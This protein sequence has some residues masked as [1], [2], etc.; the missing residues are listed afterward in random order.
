MNFLELL[1][2][3]NCRLVELARY[4]TKGFMVKKV[5]AIL[6]VMVLLSNASLA[7]FASTPAKVVK[8]QKPVAQKTVVKTTK[9]SKR[10]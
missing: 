8:K 4:L 5:L 9:K 3:K 2:Y 10:N 6:T 7:S 1:V